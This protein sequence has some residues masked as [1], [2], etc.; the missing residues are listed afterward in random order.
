MTHLAIQHRI[1]APPSSVEAAFLDTSSVEE[2]PSALRT[3]VEAALLSFED[4]G[5]ILFRRAHYRL[6]PGWL[7]ASLERISGPLGWTEEITWSRPLHE[8]SFEVHPDLPPSLRG[9]VR[10]G[11]IY[12]IAPAPDGGT[13]RI[14]EGELSVRASVL[15]PII[16]ERVLTM[17]SD[18]FAGEAALLM[19]LSR[20]ARDGEDR[21]SAPA[22][23]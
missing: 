15:R 19:A 2:A 11:G 22:P 7:P 20:R 17:L 6:G 1:S 10:C 14:I 8:G 3:V 4:R 18:H 9:R 12:R 16:E 23:A 13:L 5:E 21:L